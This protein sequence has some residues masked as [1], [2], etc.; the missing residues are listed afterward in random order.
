MNC[1]PSNLVHVSQGIP[2]IGKV[3]LA[4][5][6]GRSEVQKYC[7]GA[8]L[9]IPGHPQKSVTTSECRRLGQWG[10]YECASRMGDFCRVCWHGSHSWENSLL[11]PSPPCFLVTEFGKRYSLGSA[12]TKRR[13][14]EECIS[15]Q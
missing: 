7:E 8:V 14:G 15:R 1:V 10:C 2:L 11:L 6:L 5:V 13:D 4:I 9:R 12:V 3:E